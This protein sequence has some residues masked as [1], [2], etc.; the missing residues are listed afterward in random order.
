MTRPRSGI[1]DRKKEVIGMQ[2]KHL[3]TAR[4]LAQKVRWEGGIVSAL[5]YGIRSEEIGD[6]ELATL[7]RRMEG[8]YDQ[9]RPSITA[10]DRLLRVACRSPEP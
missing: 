6:P 2:T 10:A 9:L 8:L 1:R 5:E 7:W 3:M 4:D